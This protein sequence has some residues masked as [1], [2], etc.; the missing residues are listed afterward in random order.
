MGGF[1]ELKGR[2]KETIGDVTNDADLEKEGEAQKEKGKAQ[3]E[4]DRARVEARIQDAKATVKGA[5]QRVA[6][7]TK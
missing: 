2:V 6:Q 7:K 3:R 5:Q 1:E 4:A